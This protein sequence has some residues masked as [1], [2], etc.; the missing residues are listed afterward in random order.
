MPDD[1]FMESDPEGGYTAD[2][3]EV[4]VVEWL[5]E[6]TGGGSLSEE[7][8]LGDEQLVKLIRESR[9][10]DSVGVPP[11]GPGW[12]PSWDRNRAAAQGW[13][14]IADRLATTT[15]SMSVDGD[16]QPNDFRYLNAVRQADYYDARRPS[17]WRA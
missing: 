11:G 17:P 4:S 13:R 10:P 7:F 1:L 3:S 6:H 9:I 16:R 2:T 8:K 12:V 14:I 15:T 5:R